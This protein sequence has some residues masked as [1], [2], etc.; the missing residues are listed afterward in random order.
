MLHDT[1]QILLNSGNETTINGVEGK[2]GIKINYLFHYLKLTEGY[3]MYRLAT[4][5]FLKLQLT[6]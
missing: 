2:I 3:I 6:F 5:D 1:S 4:S